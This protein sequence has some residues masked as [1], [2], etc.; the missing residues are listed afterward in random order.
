METI[1]LEQT[2]YLA[3]I[4][5]VFAIVASL[6]YLSLQARQ[7]NRNTRLESVHAMSTEFNSFYDM[8]A[9]NGDLADIF[10]RG[11]VDLQSLDATEQLRFTLVVTR[12]FRTW[13]EQYF[14]WREGAMDDEFWQSWEVLLSDAVQYTRVCRKSCQYAGINS[15]RTFKRLWIG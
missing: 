10:N 11:H 9:S 6:I 14:Q 4:V 2:A 13:H 15:L 12:I 3:E 5:G 8:L 7:D 1:T